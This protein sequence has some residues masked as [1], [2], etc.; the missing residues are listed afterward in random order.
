MSNF[1]K[2]DS[3]TSLLKIF[4]AVS[5]SIGLV[6]FAAVATGTIVWLTWPVVVPVVVPGLVSANFI[7]AQ[8][9]WWQAVCLTWLVSCFH[10]FSGS[11]NK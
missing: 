4:L 1:S 6:I 8:I 11:F 9:S 2:K 7:A 10:N 3:D 5:G